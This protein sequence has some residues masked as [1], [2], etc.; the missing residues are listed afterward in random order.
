MSP[1]TEFKFL[2]RFRCRLK[3]LWEIPV[4]TPEQIRALGGAFL[5]AFASPSWASLRCSDVFDQPINGMSWVSVRG[6]EGALLSPEE[7][8]RVSAIR[9][10]PVLE[11]WGSMPRYLRDGQ[12]HQHRQFVNELLESIKAPASRGDLAPLFDLLRSSERLGVKSLSRLE[13]GEVLNSVTDES[14]KTSGSGKYVGPWWIGRSGTRFQIRAPF[15]KPFDLLTVELDDVS[16]SDAWAV[17]VSLNGIKEATTLQLPF[18]REV[19]FRDP[20]ITDRVRYVYSGGR[21]IFLYRPDG[22]VGFI[23]SGVGA[24]YSGGLFGSTRTYRVLYFYL[25]DG[26]VKAEVDERL[27][28][29]QG[30]AQVELGRYR[31]T[32]LKDKIPNDLSRVQFQEDRLV[33]SVR[34]RI[35]DS[36]TKES[37]EIPSTNY[38]VE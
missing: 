9:P 37:M 27:L 36:Y 7:R 25:P 3:R 16:S 18:E 33:D 30:Y 12:T 6:Q 14:I 1:R 2:K 26:S 5:V 28:D 21:K 10:N 22:T 15:R 11:K 34:F 8:S 17:T 23:G 4:R 38:V 32:V 35:V 13:F 31:F 19:E 29:R 20:E 24:T